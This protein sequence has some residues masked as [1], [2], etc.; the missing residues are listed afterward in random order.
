MLEYV[1]LLAY[2]EGTA[3]ED[4]ALPVSEGRTWNEGAS[5]YSGSATMDELTTCRHW[6][7]RLLS[8]ADVQGVCRKMCKMCEF[9]LGGMSH[10]GG[11]RQRGVG[12][13][14]ILPWGGFSSCQRD[15]PFQQVRLPHR[16][17]HLACF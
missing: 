11:L 3:S 8:P 9:R 17:R 1:S 6:S 7:I 12:H 16:G 14:S 2:R 13:F 10:S 5:M 15:S 4:R